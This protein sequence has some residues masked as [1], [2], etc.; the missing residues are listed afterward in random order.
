M[1]ICP[2]CGEEIPGGGKICPGC[3]ANLESKPEIKPL[4]KA[5]HPYAFIGYV[6]ILSLLIIGFQTSNK[7]L[8]NLSSQEAEQ[9]SAEH[10][11][12]KEQGQNQSLF[13]TAS[14]KLYLEVITYN[15]KL[16]PFFDQ[17]KKIEQEIAQPD[18]KLSPARWQELI[19]QIDH[20]SNL[21]QDLSTPGNLGPCRAMVKNSIEQIRVAVNALSNYTN[22]PEPKIKTIFEESFL[23][24]QSQRNYCQQLI[25]QVTK[26]LIP[27]LSANK[28]IIEK[29][30]QKSS[31]GPTSPEPTAP[32]PQPSEPEPI[33]QE[34]IQ[35]G[36]SIIPSPENTVPPALP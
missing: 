10:I 31:P 5:L 11:P 20:L 2:K 34:T 3:G 32:L 18:Y 16:S 15:Q 14:D 24:A 35:E 28:E 12:Q 1:A 36:A 7:F 6:L 19:Q 13:L 22:N 23:T 33:S 30:L 25:E 26:E 9:V 21:T 29:E 8:K 4:P 27:E 17:L